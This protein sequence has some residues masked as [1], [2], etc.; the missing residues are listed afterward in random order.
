VDVAGQRLN[1]YGRKVARLAPSQSRPFNLDGAIVLFPRDLRKRQV[2]PE[3]FLFL[4]FVLFGGASP[5]V[6][7][8][9]SQRASHIVGN[10][11]SEIGVVRAT[12]LGRR[13][14]ASVM[15]PRRTG[16]QPSDFT[17]VSISLIACMRS[18]ALFSRSRN[19]SRM[20]WS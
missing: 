5:G 11:P 12:E 4:A 6:H 3:P 18:S 15:P 1:V 16:F 2:P 7:I 19:E 17:V 8:Q 14:L 10:S 13:A 20:P 9:F